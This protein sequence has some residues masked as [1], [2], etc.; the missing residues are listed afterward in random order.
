MSRL[1]IGFNAGPITL[2]APSGKYIARTHNLTS[3]LPLGVVFFDYFIGPNGDDN[4]PGT[5][6]QPW[7]MSALNTKWSTYAG[8]RIG[9]IGDQGVIQYGRVGG[10]QTSIYS[11][12][13]SQSGNNAGCIFQI[14][15]GSSGSPTYIG[16]CSSAGQYLARAAVIDCSNPSGGAVPTVSAC[17]MGQSTYLATLQPSVWGYVVIDG[18]VIKNF[19]FSAITFLGSTS[20]TGVLHGNQVLNCELYNGGNVPSS[21]NPGAI[22]IVQNSGTIIQNNKIHDLQTISG[23]NTFPWGFPAIVSFRSFGTIIKNNTFYNCVGVNTKDD[24]QDAIISYNYI[25]NGVFGTGINSGQ[26]ARAINNITPDVGATYSVHH[27]IIIGEAWAFAADGVT[28]N[29]GTVNIYNNTFYGA[30]QN[31][32]P[33]LHSGNSSSTGGTLNFYN[34]VVWNDS[35]T[36]AS[37][38]FNPGAAWVDNE[39]GITGTSFDYN[40]YQSNMTFASVYASPLGQGFSWWQSQGF[41]SHSTASTS[42]PFSTAPTA[43]N[44]SSFAVT[45]SATTAGRSGACCG[46]LDGSGNVGCS[47]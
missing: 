26:A 17:V 35:G 11:M 3:V 18:L 6:T 33:I 1:N 15:G 13:Q 47:F 37:G 8:K 22:Q 40:W 28:N 5:L 21:N 39:W 32:Y 12:I 38:S 30:G 23:G 2:Y 16:S 27:N 7:S 42:S 31:Q 10:V 20:V 19:T 41:D 24:R 29:L 4:N 14:Q 44:V 25:E 43:V 46:A 9:I 34:N 45:G 36:Y